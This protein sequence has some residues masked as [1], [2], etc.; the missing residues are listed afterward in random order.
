MQKEAIA[1][2]NSM[3]LVVKNQEDRIEQISHE[4]ELL[5]DK[6]E[7]VAEEFGIEIDWLNYKAEWKKKTC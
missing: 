6:V 3:I 1:R 7:E 5:K 4:K 2:L